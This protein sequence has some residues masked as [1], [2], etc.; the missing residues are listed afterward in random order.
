[1]RWSQPLLENFQVCDV[2][3]YDMLPFEDSETVID[4]H[5]VLLQ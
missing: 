4:T 5:N 3:G 2:H 1:M